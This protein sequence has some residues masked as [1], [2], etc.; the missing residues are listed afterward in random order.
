MAQKIVSI[1][2]SEHGARICTIE[3]TFR[4]ARLVEVREVA[5][6][7]DWSEADLWS[8]LRAQLPAAAE[9]V[10]VGVDAAWTSTRLLNFPFGDAKKVDSAVA[11][12]LEGQVPFAIEDVVTAHT[13]TAKTSQSVHLLAGITTRAALTQLLGRLAAVRIEPRAV[14]L[15]AAALGEYLAAFHDGPVAVAALGGAESHLAVGGP[16]LQFAR[17]MR[18]GGA[19]VDRAL[20]VRLGVDLAEARRIKEQELALQA[21]AEGS[22]PR[23]KLARDAALEGLTPLVT[24][25][26]TTIK[27]LPPPV[28]PR[29]LAIT[30]GL[31]RL[32][33]LVPY[34][35][36]RLGLT[37]ELLDI[38]A[39]T[40]FLAGGTR[41]VGPQFAV[42]LAMAVAQF[43]RGRELPLNFRRGAFAYQGDIQLYRGQL[44]R[45]ALGTALVL[46][47]AIG[48]SAVRYSM[49][50]REE[51]QIDDGFCVATEKIVG[52]RI[53]DATAALATLR[54]APGAEGASIP[55]FSA[56]RLWEMLA[57]AIGRDTD[58]VFDELDLRVEG[59]GGQ[60]ERLT[61]RGEA[62]SFE[63]TEKMVAEIRRD[64]CV[65]DAEVSKLR[66]TSGG[67]RVEF[68]LT[69][70]VA[71]PVGVIPGVEVNKAAP[72]AA[73]KQRAGA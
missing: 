55:S 69:V 52:R 57:R 15:Q 33:G 44:T 17:S 35:Q 5:R 46:L 32:P 2:V 71:C 64:A 61:G 62:A 27:A 19:D 31:S 37:V 54:Q 22:T 14:M 16:T 6:E 18:A 12:E 7:P 60:P 67:G 41:P 34:L 1:D 53:C 9:S 38:R 29:R 49:L 21:P 68:H 13:I 43:R 23:Q 24:A 59:S 56:T 10:V 8:Q 58:V 73:G 48:T 66:R 36:A 72:A 3:A 70:K 39:A 42:A 11:F 47:L 4:R 51:R 25:L 45:A 50:R 40:A 65:Q 20:A 28:M 63:A 30:G 26:L